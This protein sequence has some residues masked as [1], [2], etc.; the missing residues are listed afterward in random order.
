MAD[1]IIKALN[2]RLATKIANVKPQGTMGPGGPDALSKFDHVL[3]KKQ[4]DMMM[5]KLS[6][7]IIDKPSDNKM[8]A[9]S[10]DDIK[11]EINEG[12][13]GSTTNFDGK[14]AMSDLFTNINND[15]LKMD[16]IIEVLSSDNTRLSRRQ[17]LA[18]Q[19]SIGTLTINTDLFS[20]LAQSISQNLNTILQTNLG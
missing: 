5:Q 3:Q 20:K 7:S 17:L 16:S 10:A 4:D 8:Q 2:Q 14:K 15:V 9:L 18:Y 6:D 12:E 19:A 13:F 1:P 11:I